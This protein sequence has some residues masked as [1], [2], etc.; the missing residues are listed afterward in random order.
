MTRVARLAVAAV[1]L[2]ALYL[3]ATGQMS[4]AAAGVAAHPD[5]LAALDDENPAYA[6]NKRLVFDMWRSIVI[7]GHVELADEML[8][9][10]YIQHSPV[11]PTG[12]AAFKAIF[13]T[14]QRGDIPELVSPPLVAI[15]AE[16]DLVVM[17]L[18]AELPEPAGGGRYS[19]AHFNLFRIE[20]GRLAEH[21]HSVQQAPGPNVA[22]PADGGPQPVTGAEGAAQLAL[23]EAADPALAA[24]KRLVFDAW[25]NLNDAGRA[26]LIGRFIAPDYLDRDPNGGSGPDSFAGSIAARTGRP[27]SEFIRAPLVAVVAQG[28]LVVVVTGREHPHPIRA[29]GTYTTTWFDMFRIA[30]GRIAEHWNAATKPGGAVPEYGD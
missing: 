9:Q 17:A 5:P 6:A 25:R 22:A 8:Q 21:W 27:V 29:G 30:D 1:L 23:L 28:D 4:P 24:N 7:A 11:L 16:G 2:Q 10:G 13:S 14:V 26:D 12:R 3:P 18:R 19:S 20:D 15:V